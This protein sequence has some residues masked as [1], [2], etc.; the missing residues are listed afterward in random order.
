MAILIVNQMKFK[1]IVICVPSIY[2]QNQMEKEIIKIY[3]KKENI[4]KVGGNSINSTTNKNEIQSFL[5]S[6]KNN[7]KCKFIISTYN[8]CYILTDNIF[9]FDFKIGDESHHLV[10]IVNEDIE[11]SYIL[12]HKINSNKTL[13][14]DCYKKNN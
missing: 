8:S 7:D 6:K 4:L 14:N 3:P 13:F 9:N 12:F 2:L 1:K 5:L 11:K 10:G